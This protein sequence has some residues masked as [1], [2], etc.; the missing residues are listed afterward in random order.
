ERSTE[1]KKSEDLAAAAAANPTGTTA[2]S[3]SPP[4]HHCIDHF[5]HLAFTAGSLSLAFDLAPLSH[6]RFFFSLFLLLSRFL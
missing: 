1:S 5:H 2:A 3:A 6:R 4:D